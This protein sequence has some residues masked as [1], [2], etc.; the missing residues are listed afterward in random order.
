MSQVKFFLNFQIKICYYIYNLTKQSMKSKASIDGHPIHPIM[1][2]FPITFFTAAVI[3][4]ILGASQN[5]EYN[6]RIGKI[7]AGA[8]ILSGLA[9]AVPGIIDYFFVVPP[10]SSGN[11]RATKH[12]LLN[13]TLV[14]LFTLAWFNRQN[15]LVPKSRIVIYE[16]AGFGLMLISGWLGGTLVYRNQIGVYNRYADKGKWNEAW[17]ELTDGVAE[18]AESGELEI[19]QMKLVHVDNK[20][21]VIGRTG[22]GYVAFDDHCTHKGGSLADGVLICGVVQCPWHGSQFDTHTGEVK[23][24]PAQNKINTYKVVADGGKIILEL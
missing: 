11:D 21:I 9:A 2:G 17:L 13:I 10:N 16:A 6:W 5:N 3:F 19:D 20:R 15:P 18:A 12:G 14:S 4:D 24:G 8:G 1:V 22:K 7:M 23:A